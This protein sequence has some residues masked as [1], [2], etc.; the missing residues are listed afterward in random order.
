[1]MKNSRTAKPYAD[2]VAV[3]RPSQLASST[4][5]DVS[6]FAAMSTAAVTASRK[7]VDLA[8]I[9]GRVSSVSNTSLSA[10]RTDPKRRREN[11]TKKGAAQMERRARLSTT[12][13]IASVTREKG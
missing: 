9:Q 13:T 10:F 1:M 2:S 5:T 6:V 3:N 11:Q 4:K 8:T 7:S 12:P